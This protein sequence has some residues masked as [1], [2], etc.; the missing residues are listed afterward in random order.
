MLWLKISDSSS[1]TVMSF[2]KTR[3]SGYWPSASAAGSTPSASAAKRSANWPKT[4]AW[5]VWRNAS[6]TKCPI[7]AAVVTKLKDRD[8]VFSQRTSIIFKST[9]VVRMIDRKRNVLI[10]VIAAALHV[11]VA[12]NAND[13]ESEYFNWDDAQDY[14]KAPT[15]KHLV[16]FLF[17]QLVKLNPELLPKKA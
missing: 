5:A 11:G 4:C 15:E 7:D 12:A 8:E 14:A 2:C 3:V 9:Q 13:P 16:S 6:A 17:N 10:S 1:R